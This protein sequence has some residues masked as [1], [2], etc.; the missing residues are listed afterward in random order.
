[1]IAISV[2]QRIAMELSRCASYQ[3][4]A[5]SHQ[6]SVCGPGLAC[7]AS[8]L[9]QDATGRRYMIAGVSHHEKQ[10][11]H[12]ETFRRKSGGPERSAAARSGT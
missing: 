9:S 11:E 8:F 10:A 3:R 6:P 5:L 2:I 12:T 1:M 4:S 7:V